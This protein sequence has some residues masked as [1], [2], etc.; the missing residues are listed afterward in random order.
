MQYLNYLNFKSKHSINQNMKN[1]PIIVCG[2]LGFIL[3][4][5]VLVLNLRNT[6]SEMPENSPEKIVQIF[7]EYVSANAHDSAYD[8]LSQK[9]KNICSSTEFAAAIYEE[10]NR[11][12]NA[13]VKLINTQSDS[14]ESIILV[15]VVE[16]ESSFPIGTSENSYPETFNL[17]KENSNWKINHLQFP[18]NCFLDLEKTGDID[19]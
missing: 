4:A 2:L 11:Y 14:V 17:T 3:I 13:T 15:E 7:L 1:V 12:S 18:G 6:Q 19:G 16:I 5:C 9:R 8:L 10:K